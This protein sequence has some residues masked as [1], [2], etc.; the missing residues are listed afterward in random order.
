MLL[1][2]AQAMKCRVN[3]ITSGAGCELYLAAQ[4]DTDEQ[5]PAVGSPAASQQVIKLILALLKPAPGQAQ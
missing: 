1:E 4:T 3:R 5:T 2:E